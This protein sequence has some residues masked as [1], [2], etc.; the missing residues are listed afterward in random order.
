MY[1]VY[2][3]EYND[4]LGENV[5]VYKQSFLL[6]SRAENYKINLVN[7]GYTV[8]ISTL[9]YNNFR[10]MKQ[11]QHRLMI[12]EEQRRREQEE[13]RR[14][15][16]KQRRELEKQRR[17]LERRMIQELQT[18][19]Q[20][21]VQRLKKQ[22]NLVRD[23][24][25]YDSEMKKF[26]DE[27]TFRENDL[28]IELTYPSNYANVTYLLETT[29]RGVD[30]IKKIEEL[31][32]IELPID[33][34][35][36]INPEKKQIGWTTQYSY[37]EADRIALET[38]HIIG[39]SL[40]EYE[41]VADKKQK[42][43]RQSLYPELIQAR[44][45]R[46]LARGGMGV[47]KLL[48]NPAGKTVGVR[49]RSLRRQFDK[50]T[51]DQFQTMNAISPFIQ[52]HMPRLFTTKLQTDDEGPYFDMEY[53]GESDGWKVLSNVNPRMVSQDIK[54]LWIE[55]LTKV[56][57]RLHFMG[58]THRDI[59]QKNIMVNEDGRLKLID[60]GLA[61]VNNTRSSLYCGNYEIGGTMDYLTK[62]LKEKANSR[63]KADFD[64][65]K[66]GDLYA[67]NII[68]KWLNQ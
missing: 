17:E 10:L 45:G 27:I 53:L 12:Q 29:P 38:L 8:E 43:V 62:Q 1:Y 28:F 37:V 52:E 34:L 13:Q 44:Q 2:T 7:M 25:Q 30:I 60:Y 26:S 68:V 61:C 63:S 6:L 9:N 21:H 35:L 31:L 14:E 16:E 24:F 55:E 41:K 15:L 50:F 42:Q 64:S 54:K 47:V 58:W 18:L 51:T 4:D 22:K 32:H 19:Q 3:F 56:V 67:L 20:L 39:N 11:E 49:K 33:D 5:W 57:K 46:Q 40:F 59:K 48:V 23:Y 65:A 36:Y 66:R